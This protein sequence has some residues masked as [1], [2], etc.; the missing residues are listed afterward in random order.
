MSTH[1]VMG[2]KSYIEIPRLKN[3]TSFF[4]GSPGP[5]EHPDSICFTYA[6]MENE[7][8]QARQADSHRKSSQSRR[9]RIPMGLCEDRV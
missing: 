2:T 6:S 8:V 1:K 9:I 3:V 5:S 7:R 4:K